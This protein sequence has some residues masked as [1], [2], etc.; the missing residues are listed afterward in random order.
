MKT[1]ALATI[2]GFIKKFNVKHDSSSEI[3][4]QVESVREYSRD[5]E[6][7]SKDDLESKWDSRFK[8]YYKSQIAVGMLADAI[9]ALSASQ[10]DQ[11]KKYLKLILG[12]SISQGGDPQ[13]SRD[14]FYE[15]HL[16]STLSAAGFEVELRE[17]DLVVKEN[18]LQQSIGVACKYPSSSKTVHQH[19][20]KGLSQLRKHGLPGVVA[21]GIDQLVV[22]AAGLKSYVDFNQGNGS[23]IAT[24][25]A[26]A[27]EELLTLVTER[28]DKYPS[29][30]P[31]DKLLVTLSLSGHGGKPARLINPTVLSIHCPHNDQLRADIDLIARSIGRLPSELQES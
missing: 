29:E 17:P 12:G 9:G 16:A 5:Q 19:I 14:W 30:D 3:W 23:P 1:S 25:Q 20:S 28:P 7:L 27:D 11:L 15:L 13:Q 24:M 21:I 26:R 8:E 4:Q 6:E 31:V 10:A 22:D 2:D 18:G